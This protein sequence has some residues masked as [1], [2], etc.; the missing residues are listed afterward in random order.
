MSKKK[1]LVLTS[2]YPYPVVGGDRLRIHEVCKEL[3]REHDLT[4]LSL[5]E[6]E[7]EMASAPP[8]DGV[9]KDVRRVLL[10][11]WRSYLSTLLA[12]PTRTPLQV[13]YYRSPAFRRE[14]DALLPGHD[15]CLAHLIR[16]G[17]YVRHAGKPAVL[18]MT[19]AISLNYQRLKQVATRTSL[20]SIVFGIEQRRLAAYERAVLD[21]FALVSLVSDIDRSF[22]TDGADRSHVITC[23]NGVDV[24][25]YPFTDRRDAAPVVTF[26]GNMTSLQNMDACVYFAEE[27]L[28]LARRRRDWTLRVIGRMTDADAARLARYPGVDVRANVADVAAES[29]GVRLGVAPVRIGAGV[30]NKVLEYMALGLP[31]I[32]SSVALEG[33][34]ARPGVDLE[35]ADT[36]QDFVERME[37]LLEDN[38]RFEAMAANGRR[39]VEQ[40]HSWHAQLEP[41]TSAV[42][43][44]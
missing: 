41:L 2:R 19:D 16:T 13:A 7:E 1:I 12:L 22:L 10:S 34:G 44:L 37:A 24:D 6:S 43:S 17:D 9:F 29:A 11:R 8:T 30:Q 40:R 15:L 28:P 5:C 26:I 38:D 42:R 18:E 14:L 31:V 23:S 39:Y 25:K 36:P 21:D 32:T 35:V 27:I 33:L 4:L 3:A 20:K